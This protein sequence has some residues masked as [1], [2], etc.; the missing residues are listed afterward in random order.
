MNAKLASWLGFLRAARKVTFQS[1]ALVHGTQRSN[2]SAF[3]TSAGK[4]RN[5]SLDKI[6]SVL[7]ELGVF[8]DGTLTPGLHRWTVTVEMI[9]GMFDVLSNNEFDRAYVFELGSG[10]GVFVVIQV[11]A[12]ILIFASLPAESTKD[13]IEGR[14]GLAEKIRVITLDRAGDSQIQALWRSKDDSAI[15][16]SL[17]T[18]MG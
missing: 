2:L 1:L 13:F 8:P 11:A 7:F 4:T 6:C 10:Y 3:V 17:L 16:S 15:Q 14:V 9:P 18:L 5:I 12:N